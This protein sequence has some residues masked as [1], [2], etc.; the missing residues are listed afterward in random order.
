MNSSRKLSSSRLA[1]FAVAAL[2]LACVSLAH[3][4]AQAPDARAIIAGV[5][6]QDK[7]HDVTFHA[8][9]NVF[10]ASGQMKHK[11]FIL[12]RIGAP[13]DSKTI[14]RFTEPAEIRGLA[15]LSINHAGSGDR[16]YLYTPAIDRVRPLSAMDRSAR[17]AD[18]DFSYEDISERALDDFTYHFLSDT[19]SMDNHKTY[20]IEVTPVAA[21]RSQYKFIYVWIAQDFPVILHAEMYGQQGQKL[22][23]LRAWEIKKESGVYGTRR[24]EVSSPA[25]NTKTDLIFDEVKFNTGLSEDLFTPEALGKVKPK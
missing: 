22:R 11:K 14:I 12:Q 24:I 18:S 23:D 16:Q 19:E 9:L 5:Y 3:S 10:D 20:K 2:L 4:A 15:L 6:E 1:Y 25:T 13:G 17:F 21:D 7:S 8:T